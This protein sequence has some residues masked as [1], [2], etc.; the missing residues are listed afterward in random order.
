MNK[1]EKMEFNR[2]KAEKLGQIYSGEIEIKP[3]TIFCGPNNTGKTYLMYGLY[4]ILEHFPSGA[5]LR[6]VDP[7]ASSLLTEGELD[8]DLEEWVDT[9]W[10]EIQKNI[11]EGLN[12]RLKSTFNSGD[13]LFKNSQISLVIDKELVKQKV[14][15]KEIDYRLAI[16]RDQL[17]ALRI[18]K[19]KYEKNAH[20]TLLA[21]KL[22]DLEKRI[23]DFI[24]NFILD[25][26]IQR[27]TF[28]IPAERNGLHLFYKE[29]SNRRTALLHHAF[30]DDFDIGKLL[31]DVLSSKYAEP[32]ADY[33]DWLN[34]LATTKKKRSEYHKFAEEIKGLVGGKYEVDQSGDIFF[35]P[36]KERNKDAVP[37]F[38][39]HLG[40]STIKSLFG[41]W[42]FLEHQAESGDVVMI[43][44]PELNLHP[45]NQR[46][47]M[48]T[49]TKLSNAGLT[50]I[51]STHS[52]YMIRELNSLIMLSRNPER[53]TS[54][55]KKYNYSQDSVIQSDSV[56]AYLFDN[57]TITTMEISEEEG[58]IATTFDLTINSLN[59][60]NDE[61]YYSNL[62]QSEQENSTRN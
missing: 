19:P 40:S 8:W 62:E 29:L 35:T 25:Q 43:D 31:K 12:Y 50:V 44:E 59:T 28:L 34:Q 27:E 47:L 48:R 26:D 5:P 32:I 37:K 17:D 30:K 38:E 42:F 58:V 4:G 52:D 57:N 6:S 16:G 9:H 51:I 61:I 13:G 1:L 46:K 20:L 55:M 14:V 23:I 39:I 7:I 18:V 3:L 54:I 21:K 49:L 36:K 53:N 2:V 24:L 60:V 41:L 10:K 33:I 15:A 11:Q 56:G 45:D 22:P